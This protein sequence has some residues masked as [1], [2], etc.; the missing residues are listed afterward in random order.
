MLSD[1]SKHTL[2]RLLDRLEQ[3]TEGVGYLRSRGLTKR[4]ADM[5]RLGV[6]PTGETGE[7]A[8]FA[9]M[10]AIPYINRAGPVAVKFRAMNDDQTPKYTGPAG[11]KTHLF[12]ALACTDPGDRIIVTEGE[13]DAIT[14]HAECGIPAV[15]VPGVTNWK[16]WYKRCIDGFNDVVILTD[17][18]VKESGANPG[19]ELAVRVKESMPQARIVTLP[20]GHDANSFYLE[21]GR[22]GVLSLI[23]PGQ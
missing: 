1:T 3:T 15:G 14:L 20:P 19:M 8:R 2:E 6:V 10:L 18:D 4:A 7:W 17:N 21:H 5:F 23:D 9:G 22:D 11:Q 13:I 16:P 12:N